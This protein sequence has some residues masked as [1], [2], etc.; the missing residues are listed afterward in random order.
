MQLVSGFYYYFWLETYWKN[1]ELENSSN[2]KW[3][4]IL[5]QKLNR[6]THKDI[7]ALVI[8]SID[9]SWINFMNVMLH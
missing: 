2:I 5:E 9:V 4:E 6:E 8:I 1:I 7:L 3:R